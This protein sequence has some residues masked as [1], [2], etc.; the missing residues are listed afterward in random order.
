MEFQN[1]N[2]IVYSSYY[3]TETYSNDDVIFRLKQNG[4]FD[5]DFATL[6]YFKLKDTD[7]FG[8]LSVDS[9]DRI[10]FTPFYYDVI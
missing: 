2:L 8:D 4:N 10:I 3:D 9:K 6:G 1:N 7:G 5:N